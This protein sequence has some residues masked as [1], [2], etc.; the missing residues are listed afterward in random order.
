MHAL[1]AP[2]ETVQYV[3]DWTNSGAVIST[4]G[5]RVAQ[6]SDAIFEVAAPLFWVDCDNSITTQG[7]AYLLDTKAFVPI[8]ESAPSVQAISNG[9][10]NL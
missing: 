8:P 7:Y 4:I 1:V 5:A 6:I 3:S 10:Q 2:H 9:T